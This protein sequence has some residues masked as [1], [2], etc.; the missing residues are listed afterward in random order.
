MHMRYIAP[1]SWPPPNHWPPPCDDW[2]P[3]EYWTPSPNRPPI[4]PNGIG[5][6][7]VPP[8]EGTTSS[9]VDESTAEEQTQTVAQRMLAVWARTVQREAHSYYQAALRVA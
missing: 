5:V 1:P 9:D 2:R 6:L 4:P 8:G 3:P 7:V